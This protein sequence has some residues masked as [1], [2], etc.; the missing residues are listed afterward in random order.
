MATPT[1]SVVIP[2]YNR[3]HLILEA[4]ESVFAQ[5]HQEYE[6]IV[7]DD[8]STDNTREVL[9]PFLHRIQ[10]VWQENQGISGARNRGILLSRGRYIA[11]LDSDD[12]WL[13]EKLAKQVVYLDAH[14]KV[15]LLCCGLW[16][17]EIGKEETRERRPQGFPK[18]FEELLQGPNFIP[19]STAIV[20]RD[21]FSK[22]GLFDPALPPIEDWDMW[23]RLARQYKMHC[24]DEILAEHRLHPTNTTKDLV[25]VYEGYRRFYAKVLK[26]YGR[27]IP[28]RDLFRSKEASFQYLLGTTYLRQRKMVK[29]L[30]NIA[31]SLG[32]KGSVGVYFVKEDSLPE[33]IKYFFKPYGAFAV[34][35]LGV[36]ASMV[37][38]AWRSR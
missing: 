16:R 23:L 7:V 21:C 25:R 4:L 3:A 10:Y 2:T 29:A 24:L 15:G 11:F 31:G 32:K 22:V 12:R 27:M 5:T 34:S 8:G 17:Y 38:P 14:P 26:L 6:V 36:I 18:N 13:P 20:P 19:T 9:A 30:W 37:V 35:A 28:D 1:V 33:K